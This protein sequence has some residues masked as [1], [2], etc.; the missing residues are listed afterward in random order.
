[1]QHFFSD[2]NETDAPGDLYRDNEQ[3]MSQLLILEARML[4]LS[5]RKRNGNDNSSYLK[6]T[7]KTAISVLISIS[8]WVI[9]TVIVRH[10]VQIENCPPE[11]DAFLSYKDQCYFVPD[12]TSQWLSAREACEN[13]GGNLLELYTRSEIDYVEKISNF[14]KAKSIWLGTTKPHQ[15]K[16]F[17][18]ASTN[19]EPS[20]NIP[21]SPQFPLDSG[22]RDTCISMISASG[23]FITLECLEESRFVCKRLKSSGTHPNNSEST[24]KTTL[25]Y[26][27]LIP[28]AKEVYS[29]MA[30]PFL[31]D[32]VKNLSW[33]DGS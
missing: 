1:M 10:C 26:N 9:V 22:L 25:S 14:A 5:F 32:N 31:I 28:W 20:F 15:D 2:T 4:D 11:Y 29:G 30:E 6:T 23:A 8:S 17:S 33:H 27:I 21:W 24:D 7:W 16:M 13:T 18:W 19:R 3:L 12:R